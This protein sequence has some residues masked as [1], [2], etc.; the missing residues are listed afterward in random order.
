MSAE[1][2]DSEE[3]EKAS[4]GGGDS[5]FPTLGSQTSSILEQTKNPGTSPAK[6]GERKETG[7]R[8]KRMRLEVGGVEKGEGIQFEMNGADKR[9]EKGEEQDHNM[10]DG[11]IEDLKKKEEAKRKEQ[12]DALDE[13]IMKSM[14]HFKGVEEKLQGD[15]REN[16]RKDEYQDGFLVGG[17][18]FSG[19][20]PSFEKIAEAIRSI[21]ITD[22]DLSPISNSSTLKLLVE[23]RT[24]RQDRVEMIGALIRRGAQKIA[25]HLK[26]SF[27]W[28]DLRWVDHWVVILKGIPVKW[29]EE[30]IKKVLFC[31]GRFPYSNLTAIGR[32]ATD[33]QGKVGGNTLLLRYSVIPIALL[34]LHLAD[35]SKLRISVSNRKIISWS[36]G[37]HPW[38]YDSAHKCD[39]CMT[40][41]PDRLECPLEETV[42]KDS[43]NAVAATM[44]MESMVLDGDGTA[45]KEIQYKVEK[46]FN[47]DVEHTPARNNR[48][49]P[50]TAFTGM[51]SSS[52][53]SSVAP[54][55]TPQPATPAGSSQTAPPVVSSPIPSAQ[56]PPGMG[57][58]AFREKDSSNT[59]YVM[60][61]QTHKVPRKGAWNFPHP[62]DSG[63]RRGGTWRGGGDK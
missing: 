15:F 6:S 20:M 32:P 18:I 38:G 11:E 9:E 40:V 34:G 4:G 43:W 31:E 56:P 33:L 17:L 54:S 36:F 42:R 1:P 19:W 2:M 48:F 14:A 13:M 8:K 62:E 39:Y 16:R 63:G 41:H 53:S 58:S 28:R 50:S 26:R 46:D 49:T 61:G 24:V 59:P 12:E 60:P 37:A 10:E 3:S 47:V 55:P 51:S 25:D 27:K 21:G 7:Q 57:P 23:V 52:S 44:D 29:G 35:P 5:I 30:D 22:N 45:I